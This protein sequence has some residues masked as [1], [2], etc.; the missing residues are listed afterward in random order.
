ME[1]HMWTAES[2]QEENST[3]DKLNH[4]PL[5][6]DTLHQHQLLYL[7]KKVVPEEPNQCQLFSDYLVNPLEDTTVDYLPST[8]LPTITNTA[9]DSSEAEFS[10]FNIFSRTFL[11]QTF[12]VGGKLT[13]DAIKMDCNSFID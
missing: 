7:Y 5:N 3:M 13:L 2:F 12:S 11:P 6:S 9:E 8:I 10:S 4:H 1:S